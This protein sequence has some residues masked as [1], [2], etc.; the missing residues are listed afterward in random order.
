MAKRVGVQ[1]PKVPTTLEAYAQ[2]EEDSPL[3]NNIC[4]KDK[5]QFDMVDFPEDEVS[6]AALYEHTKTHFSR[7]RNGYQG[8]QICL[9]HSE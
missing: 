5:G 6:V 3:G 7:K 1:G 4:C 9:L 8:G 2:G